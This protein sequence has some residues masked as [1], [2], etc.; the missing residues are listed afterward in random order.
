MAKEPRS[1]VIFFT[2]SSLSSIERGISMLKFIERT[3]KPLKF[4]YFAFFVIIISSIILF[5]LMAGNVRQETYE[6]KEFQIAP[7]AI[8]SLKTVEDTVKT[9]EERDRAANEVTPVYQFSDDIAKNRQTIA[10]N[11]FDHVIT[12]KKD[13]EKNNKRVTDDIVN[14]VAEKLEP[15][16]QEEKSLDIDKETI[17]LLLREKAATLEDTQNEVVKTLQKELSKP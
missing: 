6:L 16:K 3:V 7:E 8:R 11:I 5:F 9:E 13:L 17:K 10:Q 14:Q 12:A 2:R 15:L 1:L 4:T